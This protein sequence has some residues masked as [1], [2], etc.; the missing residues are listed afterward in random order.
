MMDSLADGLRIFNLLTSIVLSSITVV[1]VFW[2]WRRMDP[3]ER[4]FSL[5]FSGLLGY[6]L[7][8]TVYGMQSNIGFRWYLL[9]LAIANVWLI[10][11]VVVLAL[12]P[13]DYIWRGGN[14]EDLR[15]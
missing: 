15:T 4:L 10:T 13:D 8:T 1:A 3:I 14:H 6:V 7:M 2:R 5:A 12:R 11:A 9:A